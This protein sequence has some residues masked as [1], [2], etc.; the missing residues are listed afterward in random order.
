MTGF[1]EPLSQGSRILRDSPLAKLT[2]T[3]SWIK[4]L[5]KVE[6]S[7]GKEAELGANI[8]AECMYTQYDIEGNQYRLIDPIV[9]YKK[10]NNVVSKDNQTFILNGLK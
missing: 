9:D 7:Y 2:R 10:S 5:Y 8:I 1:L 4:R 3:Q 6:F